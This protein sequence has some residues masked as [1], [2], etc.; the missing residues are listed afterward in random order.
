MERRRFADLEPG[1]HP[2][3][4]RSALEQPGAAAFVVVVE[5]KVVEQRSMGGS[6]I[7]RSCHAP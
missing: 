2:R 7:A 3:R 6:F 4:D 5:L 1:L